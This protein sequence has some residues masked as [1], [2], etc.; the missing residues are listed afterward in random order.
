M[1]CKKCGKYI[2][3]E[4]KICPYCGEAVEQIK[5][6]LGETKIIGDIDSEE[7]LVEI[8]EE[9]EFV[10]EESFDF[11]EDMSSEEFEFEDEEEM[12]EEDEF[13]DEDEDDFVAGKAA[14]TNQNKKMNI[15]AIAVSA[16]IIIIIVIAAVVLSMTFG[17]PNE[18]EDRKSTRL[19]S[20]LRQSRI[21]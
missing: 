6:D 19:S 4:E 16:G 13:Y 18:E 15:I 9:I 21:P 17:S 20:H 14:I 7:K 12:A 2:Q 11:P 10:E 3:P 5:E 1:F 8:P